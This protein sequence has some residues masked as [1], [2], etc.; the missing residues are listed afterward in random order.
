VPSVAPIGPGLTRFRR[1]APPDI[2]LRVESVVEGVLVTGTV[3]RAHRSGECSRWPRPGHRAGC[4]F[5]S[6][7]TLRL[8]GPSRPTE[9]T[10]RG[11][12]GGPGCRRPHLLESR[13]SSSTSVGLELTV[14]A[15]YADPI[16]RVCARSGGVLPGGAHEP[17]P[18]H[19]GAASIPVAH[20]GGTCDVRRFRRTRHLSG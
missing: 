1:V 18:H 14:Y 15:R 8:P 12:R 9:A 5:R 17:C 7:R 11:R 10:T 20:P 16:A 4:R 2:D 6:D 13:N 3:S 19:H